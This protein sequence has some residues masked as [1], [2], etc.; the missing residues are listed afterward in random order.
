MES[1]TDALP[2]EFQSNF[3][4]VERQQVMRI[5]FDGEAP[6]PILAKVKVMS[7]FSPYALASMV[8]TAISVADTPVQ[9]AKLVVSELGGAPQWPSYDAMA[10]GSLKAYGRVEPKSPVKAGEG[11]EEQPFPEAQTPIDGRGVSAPH[12]ADPLRRVRAAQVR[13]QVKGPVLA[14]AKP[15]LQTGRFS[16]WY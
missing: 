7:R 14:G 10:V 2:A 5:T 11:D 16:G 4:S 3:R 13:A 6:F 9:A 1:V 12:S 15:A 8:R